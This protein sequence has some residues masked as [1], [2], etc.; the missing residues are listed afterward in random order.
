MGRINSKSLDETVVA[1]TSANATYVARVSWPFKNMK[2]AGASVCAPLSQ[3]NFLRDGP[4]LL[5]VPDCLHHVR[6]DDCAYS[7]RPFSHLSR[8]PVTTSAATISDVCKVDEEE[9]PLA[10]NVFMLARKFDSER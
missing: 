6:L 8:P 4:S 3:R 7:L 9:A 1:P 2:E 10:L 5:V